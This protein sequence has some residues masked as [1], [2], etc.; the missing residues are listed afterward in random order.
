MA[1]AITVSGRVQGVGS[2]PF[3]HRLATRLELD[4]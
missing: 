2:R 3:V 4:G 1:Q